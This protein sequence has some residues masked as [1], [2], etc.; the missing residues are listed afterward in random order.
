MSHPVSCPDVF[1]AADREAHAKHF[2]ARPRISHSKTMD[3]GHS[4][5]P[6]SG[7]WGDLL[8]DNSPQNSSKDT[9]P[10]SPGPSKAPHKPL[11]R[12]SKTAAYA[13]D[14]SDGS[15]IDNAPP[16]RRTRT[17][18]A[19]APRRSQ[20]IAGGA[21]TQPP[22]PPTADQWA[23]LQKEYDKVQMEFSYL[24]EKHDKLTEDNKTA[25]VKYLK[26]EN[27]LRSCI[28]RI[29]ERTGTFCIDLGMDTNVFYYDCEYFEED[30]IKQYAEAIVVRMVCEGG[31]KLAKMFGYRMQELYEANAHMEEQLALLS[32][33]VRVLKGLDDW[34]EIN[35]EPRHSY[36]QHDFPSMFGD[37]DPSKLNLAQKAMKPKNAPANLFL[38]S[39][40]SMWHNRAEKR[41]DQEKA[42]MLNRGFMTNSNLKMM[43]KRQAEQARAEV[44]RQAYF[45]CPKCEDLVQSLRSKISDLEAQVTHLVNSSE[46]TAKLNSAVARALGK[47]KGGTVSDKEELLMIKATEAVKVAIADQR[48]HVPESVW[49]SSL[50]GKLLLLME[51]SPQLRDMLPAFGWTGDRFQTPPNLHDLLAALAKDPENE[52]PAEQRPE[53]EGD[54]LNVSKTPFSTLRSSLALSRPPSHATLS[55]CTNE[56]HPGSISVDVTPR[57]SLVKN[58]A[59]NASPAREE[60]EDKF[61]TPVYLSAL[62]MER[63]SLKRDSL[64][65]DF[66]GRPSRP[67]SQQSTRP[68][69]GKSFRPRSQQ[70]T[71]PDSQQ[72]F[73]IASQQSV[74]HDRC[75]TPV[76]R[77]R[78][79]VG[80]SQ[81]P[82]YFTDDAGRQSP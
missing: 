63:P 15:D 76:E 53:D 20:A 61:V 16:V 39:K 9:S 12:R 48:N 82:Q 57:V 36:N 35:L 10:Q 31:G 5:R 17:E 32:K 59:P 58:A 2:G 25:R 62:V 24:K 46:K 79:P 30:H 3:L 40:M 64:K 28:K 34:E 49:T 21:S 13:G 70:S 54:S 44:N 78:T 42:D 60:P 67:P 11:A 23:K 7:D 26:E 6:A 43:A 4:N 74:F 50:S 8:R 71:R 55:V 45:G 75:Q 68:N 33:E 19:P 51:G 52:G 1:S 37:V 14:M 38:A 18:T 80:R 72:S 47:V 41:K 73:R 29:E 77:C 56:E 27:Y 65:E 22:E 69:S 81:T 66:F